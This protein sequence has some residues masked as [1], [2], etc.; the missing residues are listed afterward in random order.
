MKSKTQHTGILEVIERLPSS[1]NGNPRYLL[2]IDG[3]ICRTQPDSSLGYKV[4]NYDG[5]MVKAIIGTY[6]G[7]ATLD[8]LW[9][10]GHDA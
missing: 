2:R 4:A 10:D 7:K 9:G 8:S 5:N 3:H 6:Y 1:E